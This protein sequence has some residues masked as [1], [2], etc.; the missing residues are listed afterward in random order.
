M[1]NDTKQKDELMTS[2]EIMA[3]L[4]IARPTFSLFTKE[5][6]GFGMFKMGSWRMKRS[7]FEKYIEAKKNARILQ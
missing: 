1:Q 6:K 5:L 2:G 7:D 4:K 3:E